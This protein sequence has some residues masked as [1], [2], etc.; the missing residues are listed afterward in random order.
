MYQELQ[1]QTRSLFP[2]YIG[3]EKPAQV[4]RVALQ[5]Q[6]RS[7]FP[8]YRSLRLS[9]GVVTNCCNLKREACSLATRG[10]DLPITARFDVAIS[11]EKPVPSLLLFSL[12]AQTEMR[13]CNLKRE[14]CSLATA[15]LA[16]LG[17]ALVSVA[18]SN[19][20]P[21]PSLLFTRFATR[22]QTCLLQSQTRSL[23]PRYEQNSGLVRRAWSC[24]NL[25]REA[26]SLATPTRIGIQSVWEV[27]QSQT[28]SL[29]PRYLRA[30]EFVNCVFQVAISNEKPVPSLLCC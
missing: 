15:K 23:F 3:V 16:V 1:S 10:D 25:K 19:E 11:N 8:R 20:K 5:S 2:R 4:I 29:F 14:A 7:L 6:T 24:C 17:V 18:I 30:L 22:P 13:S 9:P 26:C 12:I 27:L 28:R 21:V